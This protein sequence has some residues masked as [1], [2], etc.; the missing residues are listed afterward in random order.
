MRMGKPPFKASDG[1]LI[2]ILEEL[3]EIT[4]G[5]LQQGSERQ[6]LLALKV[7][8]EAFPNGSLMRIWQNVLHC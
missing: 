7:R 4:Q 6:V 8:P 3:E 1:G 5:K 2:D